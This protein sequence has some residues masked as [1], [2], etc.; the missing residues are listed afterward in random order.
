ML[1]R[2]RI[3]TSEFGGTFYTQGVALAELFNR[4][5]GH[6]DQCIVETSDASIHNAEL[7]ETAELE[8]GFMAS[9]WIG[10]AKD[11]TPPF[12]KK[13]GL[14]MV[15]PANAGPIFFITLAGSPIQSFGD[16]AGKRI[17]IGARGSGMEQHVHT[18]FDVLG[19]PFESFTPLHMGFADGADALVSGD[20]DAQFQ[21]PIPNKVMTG[22]SRRANV[23]VVCYRPG[24]I[25]KILSHVPFYR[26]IVMEKG[27]FR[28][29][30]EDIAQIAVVNVLVTHEAI[31]EPIVYDMARLIIE[32][33]DLLPERNALFKGLRDLFE[34]LRWQ[35]A[36][37][38]EFA[39]VLLHPGAARA[40]REAGWLR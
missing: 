19:I 33:L 18:L 2:L 22:L 35:G 10:R 36:N 17:A 20:I 3:G 29:L 23:R 13:I 25:E 38:F 31:P 12:S 27:A 14:R 32:H 5:R 39:G 30:H 28:G 6:G 1:M 34:P 16:F 8:F 7:L 21:P 11:G 9:N 37:A 15:A 24:Q 26:R 4:G 40:Y